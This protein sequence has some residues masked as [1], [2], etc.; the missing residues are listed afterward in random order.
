MTKVKTKRPQF[1]AAAEHNLRVAFENASEA[2]NKIRALE[3]R[4][5]THL[6]ISSRLENQVKALEEA[7]CPR[8]AARLTALDIESEAARTAATAL[9]QEQLGH[10]IQSLQR[11][12]WKKRLATEK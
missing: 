12:Y 1:T 5:D 11:V 3:Q 2:L 7:I 8:V 6:R 10:M 4:E 9:S